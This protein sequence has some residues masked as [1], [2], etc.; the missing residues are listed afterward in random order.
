MY[1]NTHILYHSEAS[2]APHPTKEIKRNTWKFIYLND[3]GASHTLH[4][5]KEKMK[6][7][8]IYMFPMIL[9]PPMIST[10]LEKS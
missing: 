10:P 6:M 3:F 1:R 8:D 7:H 5:I 9:G 4:S 2:H